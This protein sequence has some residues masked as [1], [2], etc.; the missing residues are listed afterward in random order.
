[1]KK[2]ILLVAI[3]FTFFGCKKEKVDEFP[4]DSFIFSYSGENTDN[5]IKFTKSDTVFLQ[6]RYPTPTEN[7]FAILQGE[8]KI[9]LNK[10]LKTLNFKK[11]DSVYTQ[12]NLYDA[13]SYLINISIN[14]KSKSIFIYG[15]RAPEELYNF[16][17]SLGTF[18]KNLVFLPTNQ[19]IEFGDLGPILPPPPPP[20]IKLTQ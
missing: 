14:G 16:V 11:F 8:E 5:S 15:D 1:M 9:K 17:D 3:V 19:I 7:F 18:K 12:K 6:K 4:F 20:P 2:G 13:E 10:Y